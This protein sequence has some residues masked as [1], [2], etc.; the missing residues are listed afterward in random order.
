MIKHLYL[1]KRVNKDGLR[2]S[3]SCQ[4]KLEEKVEE[5]IQ[6]AIKKAKA[7]KS[8]TLQEEH[9]GEIEIRGWYK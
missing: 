1:K 9:F 6:E 7:E 5:M 2:L 4:G 3:R 8:S